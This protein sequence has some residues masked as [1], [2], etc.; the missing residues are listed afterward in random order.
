MKHLKLGDKVYCEELDKIG[1][2]TVTNGVGSVYGKDFYLVE[3]DLG[4][5]AWVLKTQLK[6]INEKKVV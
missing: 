6:V 4:F 1:T 2:I 3:W 5:A